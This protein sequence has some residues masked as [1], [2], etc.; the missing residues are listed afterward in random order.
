MQLPMHSAAS[1][2]AETQNAA[3][4]VGAPRCGTTSLAHGW[5]GSGREGRRSGADDCPERA[6]SYPD[7]RKVM[8]TG[9]LARPGLRPIES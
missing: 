1:A 6:G 8:T 2:T 5:R 4:I 7:D 9:G 3:F